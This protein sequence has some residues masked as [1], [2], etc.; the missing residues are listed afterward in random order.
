MTIAPV[1]R[2]NIISVIDLL[3]KNNLPAEDI[4]E[5][6]KLF[7]LENNQAV[8]GTIAIEHSGTEGLLRSL[9]VSEENRNKGSGIRL[10]EFIEGYGKDHGVKNLYLLTTTAEK[11]FEK[12]GY[13]AIDRKAVP[14]FIKM[15]SEFSS[16]CPS[17]AVL[18]KKQL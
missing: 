13:V 10:V 1:N 9:A 18:M 6:T 17:S 2:E 15:T 14:E 7:V 5:I 11:F 16:V 12:R 4:S 3:K 8:A